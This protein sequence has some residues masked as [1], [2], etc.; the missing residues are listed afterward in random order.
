MKLIVLLDKIIWLLTVLLFSS[1]LLLANEGNARFVLFGITAILGGCILL[2]Y[3]SHPKITISYFHIFVGI[4][5]LFCFSSVIWAADKG[6]AILRALTLLQILICMS[7]L[8]IHYSQ[9]D[10]VSELLDCIRWAGYI[11]TIF[12]FVFYGW[13]TIRHALSYGLRLDSAFANVNS[14]A[15]LASLS[16]VLTI[17]KWLY[18]KFSVNFLL[19]LPELV[20]IAACG[21]RKALALIILGP[22]LICIFRYVT[23]N[24]F[25]TAIRLFFVLLVGGILLKG[26]LSLNMFDGLNHRMEG[27]FSAYT[28]QG[29]TD[30][31]AL[32]RMEMVRIG[33]QQFKQTPWLGIGMGNS[34][35]LT[36]DYLGENL[37]YLHNNY[38]DLLASGGI[39]G[40]FCYY[41]ILLY[42]L[43][44]LLKLH[45]LPNQNTSAV[46]TMLI[47]QF[48]II[49]WGSV[50]YY[51]KT[52]YFYLLVFYL[53]VRLLQKQQRRHFK[54]A[55]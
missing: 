46:L 42:P 15:M 34:F 18:D 35:I 32:I 27:L 8:W 51:G 33:W 54:D 40:T 5:L 19:I 23:K 52:T 21:S 12:A 48:A 28:G 9:K 47:M 7:V 10:S 2:R 14:I 4:F 31:S 37:T 55:I 17:H 49:D 22:L 45:H 39:V 16:I 53:Q 13:G 41:L 11:L 29:S 44:W 20:I 43:Y 3:N 24:I 6:A 25:S 38:V 26:L 36:I 1:F 30:R 50:S